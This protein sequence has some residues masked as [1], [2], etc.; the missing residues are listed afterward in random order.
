MIKLARTGL[1]ASSVPHPLSQSDDPDCSTV[2]ALVNFQDN[3]DRESAKS[4]DESTVVSSSVLSNQSVIN[5]TVY[6]QTLIFK[7]EHNGIELKVC[8]ILDSGSQKSYILERVIKVLKL[9]PKSKQTIVHDAIGITDPTEDAMRKHAHSDF[10]NQFKE[11][12]SVLLMD[13]SEP[14][15]LPRDRVNDAAVFEVVGVD[16]AEPLYVK[17][18]QKSW[19]VLFI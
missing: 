13:G 18:G 16:L 4:N 5:E 7:I 15:S 2:A 19:I 17:G 6:L 11:N 9:R 12:L 1:G 14:I 10:L 8:T 3:S